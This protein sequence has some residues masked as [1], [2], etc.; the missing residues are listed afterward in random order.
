MWA[1]PRRLGNFQVARLSGLSNGIESVVRM[2]QMTLSEWW[3]PNLAMEAPALERVASQFGSIFADL[4]CDAP[5]ARHPDFEDEDDDGFGNNDDDDDDD[6]GE[7]EEGF[8]DFDDFDDDDDDDDEE[9]VD[10]YDDEEEIFDDDDDFDRDYD[11]YDDDYDD[12]EDE[13]EDAD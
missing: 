2:D 3:L 8:D 9:E 10:D 5:I 7:D 12:E 4:G 11:T 6:F 1:N 13:D